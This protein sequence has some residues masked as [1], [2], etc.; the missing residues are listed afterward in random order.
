MYIWERGM[1]I[2]MLVLGS[3]TGG[4]APES[5]RED[6]MLECH[7]AEDCDRQHSPF[8]CTAKTLNEMQDDKRR[9][10]NVWGVFEDGIRLGFRRA[11]RER[12]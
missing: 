7:D 1:D 9:P 4:R 3:M 11:W 8:E 12:R 2:G 6:Y 5:E 10:Y